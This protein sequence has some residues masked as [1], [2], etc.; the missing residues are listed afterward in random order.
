MQADLEAFL[1]TYNNDR[2]HQGR[3]MK[4]RTPYKAFTDGLPKPVKA[5][6]M[7]KTETRKAAL[8]PHARVRKRDSNVR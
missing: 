4:G 5:K 2:P 7:T 8:S 3:G 6:K 1:K